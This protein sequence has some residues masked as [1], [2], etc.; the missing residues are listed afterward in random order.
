MLLAEQFS[1]IYGCSCI[2]GI[3]DSIATPILMMKP[4]NSTAK[5]NIAVIAINAV[6]STRSFFVFLFITILYRTSLLAEQAGLTFFSLR[7]YLTNLETSKTFAAP[8]PVNNVVGI[9]PSHLA[10]ASSITTSGFSFNAFPL[11]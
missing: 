6:A 7:F 3:S 9:F 4:L 5:I 10:T 11:I 2:D 1:I 8:F